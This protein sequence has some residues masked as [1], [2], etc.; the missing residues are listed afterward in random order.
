MTIFDGHDFSMEVFAYC[1]KL[2][3]KPEHKFEAEDIDELFGV[4]VN[5]ACR[6]Q[7]EL[8]VEKGFYPDDGTPR[9]FGE[10]IALV[11]SELSEA[12]EAH[13]KNQQDT[14]LPHRSGVEVEL[15]DALW[16]IFDIAG[17]LGLDLGG[18]LRE[19]RTINENRPYKHGKKF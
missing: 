10:A 8:C 15:A 12:L 5:E 17:S 11:H 2:E 3:R 6:R 18:A 4:L 14:H 9:N 16:R 19:K 7:Y 13:R 1:E